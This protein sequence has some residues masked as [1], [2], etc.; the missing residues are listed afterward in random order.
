MITEL[1]YVH[2]VE[3][4]PSTLSRDLCIFVDLHQLQV[5]RQKTCFKSRVRLY[6]YPQCF[7]RNA[8]GGWIKT[9][10]SVHNF[11]TGGNRS[12]R[13]DASWIGSSCCSW[14]NASKWDKPEGLNLHGICIATRILTVYEQPTLL[15][16]GWTCVK[17]R[18]QQFT[19]AS[20]HLPPAAKLITLRPC[21]CP[22]D[23]DPQQKLV[24]ILRPRRGIS[25]RISA[26]KHLA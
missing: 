1:D 23:V 14:V 11:I 8:W 4:T 21:S 9:L 26:S 20:S 22:E 6:R 13:V 16:V 7:T 2:H 18:I 25:A 24:A 3:W 10:R 12:L 17:P 19:S 15:R 5:M